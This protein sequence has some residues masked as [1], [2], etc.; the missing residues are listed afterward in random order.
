MTGVLEWDGRRGKGWGRRE[1]GSVISVNYFREILD[2]SIARNKH[3]KTMT[4]FCCT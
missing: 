4:I 3:S 1:I 2:Y